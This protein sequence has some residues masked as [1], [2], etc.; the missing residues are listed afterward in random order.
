MNALC[1]SSLGALGHVIKILP[2]KNGYKVDEFEPIYLINSNIDEKWFLVFERTI[3]HL[4]FGNVRLLQLDYQYY[5][6]CFLSFFLLFFL[7]LLPLSTF[8]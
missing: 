8:K 2:A 4:S 6:S 5:F 3:N 1:K 7:F